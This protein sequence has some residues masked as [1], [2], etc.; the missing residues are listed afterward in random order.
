[1]F[2]RERLKSPKI[3]TDNTKTMSF[4]CKKNKTKQC[5][6]GII[7]NKIGNIFYHYSLSLLFQRL[8]IFILVVE[9]FHLSHGDV[10]AAAQYSRP[11]LGKYH[12]SVYI[13]TH[14]RCVWTLVM[15]LILSPKI[16][17]YCTIRDLCVFQNYV[18]V[19]AL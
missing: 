7:D 1:M 6:F 5:H 2:F 17:Q 10:G 14:T 16:F 12:F 11:Y 9:L 19:N 8:S 18:G 13:Y 4:W 3:V 15:V